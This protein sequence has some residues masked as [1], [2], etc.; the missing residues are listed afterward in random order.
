MSL[1]KNDIVR[2]VIENYA[3]DGQGIARV[4]GMVVFVKN[5]VRG[6]ECDLHILK[7]G[8]HQAYAKIER[9]LKAS[10]YR[11]T[12][13]C[14]VFS[15]CGGCD[16]LHLRYEEELRLKK[17]RVE[18]AL[19]R[20]GGFSLP[21]EEI[22]PS[23]ELLHYRNKAQFPVSL[24]NGCPQT[25]FYRARS[26]DIVPVDRCLI[27]SDAANAAAAAVRRWVSDCRIP[28]YDEKNKKGMLRHIYVRTAQSGDVLL[29]LV[30]TSKK[31]PCITELIQTVTESCPFVRSIVININR[32]P[33]NAI[34]GKRE[35]IIYGSGTI[36]ETLC[37]LT[38]RISP[39]SFF[40]INLKQAENL[41]TRA[42]S[43][44]ALSGADRALDLYCGTGTITLLLA[45][46][47]KE[48]VGAEIV[49]DAVRDAADNAGRNNIQ[50]VRFLCGDAGEAAEHLIAEGFRPDV[51]CVDPPRKGLDEKTRSAIRLLSPERLVYVSCDPATMARDVKLLCADGLYRPR[52]LSAFDMFPRTSHV[53]TVC[54]LSRN[55]E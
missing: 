23:P 29:C 51:I 54:L 4:D 34:L 44:A 18:D 48:A 12:P 16:F 32:D 47:C 21:A 14:P 41:Y 50:N 9:L 40:Q 42:L 1:A 55:K 39:R 26:H 43:Y 35:M 3:A 53:E 22:V 24:I 38:F 31:L 52:R 17:E 28:V 13:E 8:K 10:P 30:S 25:G 7:T 6:D 15:T 2:A 5:A 37:G 36:D 11:E 19:L 46:H 49:E 20:I 45:Q 27:Q 33:G